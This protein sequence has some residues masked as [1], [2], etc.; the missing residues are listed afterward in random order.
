MQ[1]LRMALLAISNLAKNP[2]VD[3]AADLVE[4][5][6]PRIVATRKQ[7]VA[8]RAP[9]THRPACCPPPPPPSLSPPPPLPP[10]INF[11]DPSLQT[12]WPLEWPSRTW[13][14]CCLLRATGAMLDHVKESKVNTRLCQ[15][16]IF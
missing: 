4:S 10:P 9:C 8:D 1:V 3:V 12:A 13:Q 7:Q 5:G 15:Q 2:K 14:G 16:C 11:L 6:L